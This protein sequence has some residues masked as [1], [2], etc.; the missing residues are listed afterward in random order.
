MN[1]LLAGGGFWGE[2]MGD[3][4]SEPEASPATAIVVESGGGFASDAELLSGLEA[5]LMISEAPVTLTSLA[6]VLAVPEA[7]IHEALA[8]L[9]AEYRG[10]TGSRSRGFEL[11]ES[12]GG[13]RIYAAPR[14]QEL[15]AGFVNLG[16]SGKLSQ[17]ALETLAVVA[18]KQP[19]TRGQVAAIRGVNVDSVMR[20]LTARGLIAECGQTNLGAILYETTA[21]FLEQTGLDSLEDLPPL[22]PY[23]P[24]NP[25]LSGVLAAEATEATETILDAQTQRGVK[26]FSEAQLGATHE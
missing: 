6:T 3:F 18:Y 16:S 17:A 11:R 20:N 24:A 25:D 2:P 7:R 12:A 26:E 9:A 5:I 23:V 15:V 4:V 19:C 14:F 13:W 8:A 1:D 21:A 10:E 22:A